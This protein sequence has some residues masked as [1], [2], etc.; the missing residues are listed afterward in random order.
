MKTKIFLIAVLSVGLLGAIVFAAQQAIV[1][2]IQ[3]ADAISP[4]TADFIKSGIK[5]A[6]E[7]EAACLIIELDTPGGLAE[8]MRMIV[9]NILASRVPVV[10]FVYPRAVPGPLPPG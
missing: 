4:G 8:S 6:E 10:V 1:Y 2:I 7:N 5:T 9:Q 3:I